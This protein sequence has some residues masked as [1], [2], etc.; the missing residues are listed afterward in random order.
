MCKIR[1]VCFI[2]IL[3]C[4]IL[5]FTNYILHSKK[6]HSIQIALSKVVM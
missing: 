2:F 3:L 4:F 6:M 1:G 5:L